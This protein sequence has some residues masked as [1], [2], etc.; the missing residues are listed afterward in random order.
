ME[1]LVETQ[2]P[3]GQRYVLGVGAEELAR[4]DHQAASIERPSRLL[5]QAAGLK[6]GMRVLDLGTGP[7]HVARIVA[8]LVG[9]TGTV[10]GLDQSVDMVA[11]ARQRAEAAGH[12]HVSFVEGDANRWRAID[13][14]DAITGRLVLFHMADPVAVIR[15]QIGNLRAGGLFIALDFD[16]GATRGEPATPVVTN[17]IRWVDEAFRAAGAWPRIGARLGTMFEN[18]GLQNVMTFGVQAYLSPSNPAGPALL[19]G[20]V[21]SLVP[22]IVQHGIATADEIDIATL[23]RRLAD[24]IHQADSVVLLP[25]VAGAW[26][27]APGN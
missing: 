12:A 21:R 17:A 9:S 14:F 27:Q 3:S 11:I 24:E 16:I 1:V 4:L 19:A 23:E 6:P 18:A 22:T 26:G 7:G 10:V 25:T 13:P 5:L 2:T 8:E 20:V 15:H